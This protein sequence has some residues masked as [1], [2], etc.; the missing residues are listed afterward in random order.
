MTKW[1]IA[2][3][4]VVMFLAGWLLGRRSVEVHSFSETRV[5][6]VF[7]EKLEPFNTTQTEVTFNVPRWMFAPGDTDTVERV[8]FVQDSVQVTLPVE[9]REYKDST[10]YAV[11]SGVSVGGYRPSLDYIETYNTTTTATTVVRDPYKWEIGPA[12]GAWTTQEFGGTWVGA[13]ARRTF[14]RFSMTASAGYDVSNHGIYGSA[15][16]SY[17]LFRK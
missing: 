9:R 14:G 7:Y 3:I 6:T 5:D 8:V 2:A 16:V 13:E 17:T 12:A 11:V 4:A 1:V 10:Y 15:R